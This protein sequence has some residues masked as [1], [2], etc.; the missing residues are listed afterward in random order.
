MSKRRAP[1]C[2]ECRRYGSG[3]PV[4]SLFQSPHI[5]YCKSCLEQNPR[6]C[7]CGIPKTFIVESSI[8]DEFFDFR[9]EHL[10]CK[11]CLD[12]DC[13]LMKI[14]IFRLQRKRCD[15]IDSVD[16]LKAKA[17]FTE[18]KGCGERKEKKDCGKIRKRKRTEDHE[19]KTDVISD[20]QGTK[21]WIV[22]SSVD[23][24]KETLVDQSIITCSSA[25]DETYSIEEEQAKFDSWLD[26]DDSDLFFH[27]EKRAVKDL[28]D[29]FLSFFE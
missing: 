12:D 7:S 22:D 21:R 13:V 18:R 23:R 19:V 25:K 26:C 17:E 24:S 20:A 11:T 4:L 27:T 3:L 29:E 6:C 14:L 10:L 9:N 1:T 8:S 28:D 16:R 5:Q 2:V 15:L